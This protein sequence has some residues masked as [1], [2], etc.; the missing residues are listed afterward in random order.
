[1]KAK[2]AG[3]VCPIVVRQRGQPSTKT[4]EERREDRTKY[5]REW[6]QQKRAEIKS[7]VSKV[8]QK[9]P[10]SEISS[11]L[12]LRRKCKDKGLKLNECISSSLVPI[13]GQK[14]R[15]SLNTDMS[16][17][18]HDKDEKDESL[19]SDQEEMFLKLKEDAIQA[20]I[21]EITPG[22]TITSIIKEKFLSGSIPECID[23][24]EIVQILQKE[25]RNV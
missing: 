15:Y 16:S 5:W 19:E 7:A 22:Q 4:E 17:H 8:I 20:P 21:Q 23:Y 11:R 12:S 24:K 14:D 10:R 6:K 2:E 25:M 3:K 13:V 18:A 1:M 9:E